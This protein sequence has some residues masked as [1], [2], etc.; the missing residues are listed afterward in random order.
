MK[1]LILA[2]FVALAV[3]VSSCGGDD[4]AAPAAPAVAFT[5]G[6]EALKAAQ[7]ALAGAG[8]YRL[9]VQQSN[10]VLPRWGGSDNGTVSVNRDGSEAR[11]YR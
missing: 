4:D 2:A 3:P 5:N 1:R 8:G 9:R 7:N 11:A 6:T 10:L